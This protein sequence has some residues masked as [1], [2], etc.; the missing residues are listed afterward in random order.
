ME[1]CPYIRICNECFTDNYLQCQVYI[2]YEN[3]LRQDLHK[4]K[5]IKGIFMDERGH[6]QHEEV[7]YPLGT[8][9][10]LLLRK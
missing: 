2:T 8:D 6:H 7:N 1:N 5:V 4:S 3:I 10:A 9:I